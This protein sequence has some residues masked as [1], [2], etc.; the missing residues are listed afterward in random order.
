MT[1]QK[2][3]WHEGQ[4]CLRWK[5]EGSIHSRAYSTPIQS[6]VP[7]PDSTGFVLIEPYEEVGPSNAVV[8]DWNGEERCRPK[9]P[10][11][12]DE[13]HG[14]YYATVENEKVVLIVAAVGGDLRAVLDSNTCELAEIHEAR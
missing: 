2:L 8:F 6:V 12:S 1:D 10:L 7:L 5:H 11:P 4:N 14:F 13:V 9:L 3:E